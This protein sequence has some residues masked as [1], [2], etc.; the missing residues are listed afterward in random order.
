MS[1]WRVVSS[2][3]SRMRSEGLV[4]VV[5][6]TRRRQGGL[7]AQ[8]LRRFCLFV[9]T[10]AKAGRCSPARLTKA[11]STLQWLIAPTRWDLHHNHRSHPG[12]LLSWDRYTQSRLH[13]LFRR[14]HPS[15]KMRATGRDQK[16]DVE[17]VRECKSTL[18]AI[19]E[20]VLARIA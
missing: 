20:K 19:W 8:C 4:A 6:I 17:W 9:N 13:L 7:R 11:Q 5:A 3:P 14:T 1:G 15:T 10:S 2:I 16:V 18:T 12:K